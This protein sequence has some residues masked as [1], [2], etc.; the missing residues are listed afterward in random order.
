MAMVVRDPMSM[1][2][3]TRAALARSGLI[4]EAVGMLAV[5]SVVAFLR[6][7][8]VG[9]A[10]TPELRVW[11]IAMASAVVATLFVMVAYLWR[12]PNDAETVRVWLFVSRLLRGWLNVCAVVSPWILLPHADPSLRS[13]MLMLYVWY[14]ATL[15]ISNAD[16]GG[17][18]WVSLA[19]L[20]ASLGLFLL[21]EGGPYAGPLTLFLILAAATLGALARLL[22]RAETRALEARW[23][24]ERDAE[25][26]GVALAAVAAER[27]AKTRFIAA[28]SHDLQQPLQA[29]SL[30]VEAALD[31]RDASARA[32]AGAGARQA[33]ASTQ[34]LIGQM[35]DHLRLEAGAVQAR[36]E[37]VAVGQLMAEVAREHGPA[38]SAAGMRL[39]VAPSGLHVMADATLLRRALGNLV[40]NAV[41]HSRGERVLIGA[42]RRGA[43]AT[44]WVIDDGAGVAANEVERLFEDYTQ[45]AGSAATAQGGFGLGLASVRRSL[46]LMAGDAGFDPRWTG[47][48]AFWVRVPIAAMDYRETTCVAV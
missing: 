7:S 41:R 27:D 37:V 19:G 36:A 8:L 35:L 11:L 44:I 42:R 14:L 38:A 25:A 10:D 3:S 47:G 39:T 34:A 46:A 29:A 2:D 9:R 23:R 30:F 16:R 4:T 45:G 20:P 6:F 18:D 21:R 40:A 43:E 33:L 17:P 1:G 24:S 48:A 26:L 13:L 12:R 28:A 5:I 15:V 31:G 22:R 32:R